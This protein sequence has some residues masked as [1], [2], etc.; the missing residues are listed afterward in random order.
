MGDRDLLDI[1]HAAFHATSQVETLA[2]SASSKVGLGSDE[3]AELRTIIEQAA[4][5]KQ[6]LV[7]KILTLVGELGAVPV[8]V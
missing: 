7:P 4:S 1:L 5:Q 8:P 6:R 3:L 2:I